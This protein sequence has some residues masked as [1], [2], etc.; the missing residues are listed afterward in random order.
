MEQLSPDLVRKLLEK[1]RQRGEHQSPWLQ[2]HAPVEGI[3]HSHEAG[4]DDYSPV[5]CSPADSPRIERRVVRRAH[6]LWASLRGEGGLP[7]AEA[8]ELLLGAPFTSHA[9]LFAVDGSRHPRIA[10]AGDML[11][12]LGGMELG[13]V[14]P[15]PSESATLGARL[16]ALAMTAMETAAPAFYD[17]D[18]PA[19]TKGE[20]RP[21]VLMRAIALPLAP[22]R[23]GRLAVTI[24][25]WRQLLSDGETTALHREL[26]AAM[27]WMGSIGAKRR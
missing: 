26:A 14:Q 19:H 6:T 21:Q 1:S 13:A 16:A 25:S 20:L 5:S 22:T 4:A 2:R 8:A 24:A 7:P 12:E 11:R 15:D 18:E 23:K 17:S 10:F 3:A 27:N 9:A